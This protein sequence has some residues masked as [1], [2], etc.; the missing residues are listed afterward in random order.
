[1]AYATWPATLHFEPE[2]ETLKMLLNSGV[3]RQ[4]MDGGNTLTRN[5]F[6]SMPVQQQFDWYFTSAEWDIFFGFWSAT[7]VKG[8]KRFLV[9]IW[10]GSAY[11]TLTAKFISDPEPTAAGV[12]DMRVSATVELRNL[13]SLD[14]GASWIVGEYGAEFVVEFSDKLDHIVNVQ[15]PGVLANQGVT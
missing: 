5:R 14:S 7:L 3:I 12:T 13:V 10:T 8:Q 2:R 11:S 1:M 4:Q 15:M 9:P 6:S